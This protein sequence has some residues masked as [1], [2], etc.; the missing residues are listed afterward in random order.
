MPARGEVLRATR[1]E[2]LKNL[3]DEG[4]DPYPAAP[5]PITHKISEMK[6]RYEE[7]KDSSVATAGRIVAIRD[8]GGLMF[9]DVQDPH[10]RIQLMVV[11]RE[12]GDKKFDLVSHTFDTGDF[13]GVRGI[14]GE[15]KRGEK[16]IKTDADSVE[17]LA[18]AILPPPSS[19]LGI[20][21]SE[22]ARRQR[23]LET[24]ANPEARERFIMRSR[25]VQMM[26]EDFLQNGFLEVETPVLDTTYGGANAKPFKTRMKNLDIDTDMYLKIS[27]ELYLKRLTVGMMGPVFEFSRN[28][29]N[30][31]RDKTHNPEFTTVEAYLPYADYETMMQLMET[32]FERIALSLLGT[33]QVKFGEHVVDFKAP[34]KRIT[35]YD[36]LKSAYRIDPTSMSDEDVKKLGEN[37]G[38]AEAESRRGDILL[39]LFE[40]AHDGKLIQPTF[41]MDYPKETSPLTKQHRKDPNLVERF[42]C[43]IG[44]WEV[45]NAYTELNNPL[46][47]RE[48]FEDQARRKEGG[49]EEAMPMDD[50][51]ITSLEYGMP[52]QGGI[53]ISI[54]RMAMILTDTHHI[55]DIILFP[56]MNRQ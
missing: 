13:I 27:P 24:M 47:Q 28:F 40:K 48:R 25:M 53:G 21:D 43:F 6:S 34:W 35:I 30:E 49:D 12:E 19:R 42:E 44:G 20:E 51:F 5:P 29:R 31:G 36:G 14:L 8:H 41:V 54:D 7:L 50:D 15:T 17:M 32:M 16:T 4:I 18:K 39:A 26:R 11:K 55:R 9:W 10:D 56:Q 2:H 23:Y 1:I 45:A 52:P 38:V 37:E 3:Q 46:D 22:T 33:T